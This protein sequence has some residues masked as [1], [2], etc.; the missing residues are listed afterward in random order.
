MAPVQVRF[1]FAMAFQVEIMRFL[2]SPRKFGSSTVWSR[3]H[4]L[5]D[6][7]LIRSAHPGL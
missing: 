7:R 3:I 4:R 2:L 1:G 6:E 5:R